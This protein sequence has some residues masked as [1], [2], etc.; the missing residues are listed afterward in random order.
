MTIASRSF[1]QKGKQNRASDGFSG[2][3]F[4]SFCSPRQ[5]ITRLAW[6]DAGNTAIER[7]TGGILLARLLQLSVNPDADTQVRATALAALD[8]LDDWLAG[9]S[10]DDVATNAHYGLARLQI[11]RMRHDP[12]SVEAIVPVTPPPGSPIGAMTE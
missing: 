10:S 1:G 5:G 9:R 12:A 6:F 2:K 4:T 3:G 8:Q 7:Q 11:E